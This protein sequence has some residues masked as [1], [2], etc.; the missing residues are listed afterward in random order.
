MRINPVSN[1]N[2]KALQINSAN[3]FTKKQTDVLDNIIVK[4]HLP[5][6]NYNERSIIQMLEEDYDINLYADANG[7]KKSVNIFFAE[8]S[9]LNGELSKLQRLTPVGIY[10]DKEHAFDVIDIE[11]SLIELEHGRGKNFAG[12]LATMALALGIVLIAA[13]SVFNIAKTKN[14]N[15]AIE[16]IT[17]VKNIATDSLDKIQKDIIKFFDAMKK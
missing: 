16:T 13:L 9:Y 12:S 7:D 2:F 14:S 3:E 11:N 17:N 5:Q 1:Q 15:K 4:S 6:E 10:D 8:K